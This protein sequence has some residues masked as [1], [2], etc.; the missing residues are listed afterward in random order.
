MAQGQQV[1]IEV[2]D[3]GY[4]IAV[5]ELG[6][7]FEPYFRSSD[8]RVERERG[9]GLG[10]S[11]VKTIIEQH[12]GRIEVQSEPEQGTTFRFTLPRV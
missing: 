12:G 4:G 1:S 6:R 5:H 9:T 7:L 3:Q 2:R 11:I 10:L 8:A